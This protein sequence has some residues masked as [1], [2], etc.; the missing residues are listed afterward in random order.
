M[1]KRRRKRPTGPGGI[2]PG[3]WY[4]TDLVKFTVRVKPDLIEDSRN[5]VAFLSGDPEHLTLTTLV[6]NA[7]RREIARLARKH[8]GGASFPQRE[9]TLRRGPRTKEERQ[10][11]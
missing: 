11:P 8:R 2:E 6:T 7:L 10:E 5:A 9:G 1:A 3:A 4:E